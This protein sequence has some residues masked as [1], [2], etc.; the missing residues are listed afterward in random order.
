[1]GAKREELSKGF[2]SDTG[3]DDERP[4]RFIEEAKNIWRIVYADEQD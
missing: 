3:G 4:V 1:M 2:A